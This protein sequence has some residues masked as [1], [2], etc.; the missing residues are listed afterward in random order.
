MQLV[1]DVRVE[2]DGI[3]DKANILKNLDAISEAIT[4]VRCE[5][6]DLIDSVRSPPICTSSWS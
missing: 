4:K 6:T 1:V 5:L 2:V 3:L